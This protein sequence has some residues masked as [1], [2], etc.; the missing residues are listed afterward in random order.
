MI[1]FGH[2]KLHPMK[3]VLI[4][5]SVLVIVLLTQCG[6]AAEDRN[7]MYANAKRVR[8]SIA[9]DIDEALAKGAI[10]G[11]ATLAPAPADTAKAA[12]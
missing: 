5:F 4:P 9:K 7:V 3:K 1:T 2:Y 6:P 12:K 10:P 11:T 8:D